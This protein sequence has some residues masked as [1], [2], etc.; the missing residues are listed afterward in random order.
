M[1]CASCVA[2]VEK[3]IQGLHAAT[4]TVN[5]ASKKASVTYDPDILST[6]DIERGINK[7]GYTATLV[8]ADLK[9]NQE[10]TIGRLRLKTSVAMLFSIPLM[11]ISMG[12]SVGQH[13]GVI[14]W[15]VATPVILIGHEF[16]T[17]GIGAVLK[18]RRAT[19]DT[20]VALGVGSAYLYSLWA[21]IWLRSTHLYYETAAFLISFILLGRHRRL[22][23]R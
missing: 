21:S 6:H 16:F 7:T 5:F 22:L 11:V 10:K 9:E 12:P 4:G 18:Y 1:N 19:M 23:N 20:L 14:Q 13:T 3:A 15:I 17:K 2:S 8:N